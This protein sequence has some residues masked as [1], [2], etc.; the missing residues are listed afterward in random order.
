MY[1]SNLYKR[2]TD[3]LRNKNLIKIKLLIMSIL[4]FT[5]LYSYL[6]DANFRGLNIIED[7]LEDKLAENK[8]K[9][10]IKDIE[11]FYSKEVKQ[12]EK[13]KK[14]HEEDYNKKSKADVEKIKKIKQVD[15]TVKEKTLLQPFYVRYFDRLYFAICTG[16]LLGYGDIYPYTI[17]CKLLAII[18]ALLTV[19]IIVY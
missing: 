18:Q 10:D 12:L 11:D 2:L 1:K 7:Q 8:L 13:I 19:S 17:I 3:F 16:C 14:I 9:E 5:V 6:D 4:I 15:D